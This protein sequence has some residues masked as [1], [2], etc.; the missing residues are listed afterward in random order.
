MKMAAHNP[1][2]HNSDLVGATNR[3]IR[4]DVKELAR[5]QHRTAV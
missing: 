1:G 5:S 3:L 2:R 4:G